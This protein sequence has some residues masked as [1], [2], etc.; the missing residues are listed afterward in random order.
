RR[1]PS[2]S[3]RGFNTGFDQG[4]RCAVVLELVVCVAVSGGEV[5]EVQMD[6]DRVTFDSKRLA[7][8]DGA[9]PLQAVAVPVQLD[10]LPLAL[11]D[12]GRFVAPAHGDESLRSS[13]A[14]V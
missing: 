2:A 14:S 1:P 5:A 11:Q 10:R 4:P 9:Q 3:R 7:A 6:L 12:R 13:H 8:L